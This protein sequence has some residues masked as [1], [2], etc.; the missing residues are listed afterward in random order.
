MWTEWRVDGCA[1]LAMLAAISIRA[2]R[3][4]L[5]IVATARLVPA[6]PGGSLRVRVGIATGR[7]VVGDLVGAGEARERGVVG[8]T[9]N[10]AAHV[11]GAVHP[12]QRGPGVLAASASQKVSRV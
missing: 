9:P 11:A 2:V 12:A 10:L 1:P 8:E 5:E 3:A 4:G 7:V 6:A